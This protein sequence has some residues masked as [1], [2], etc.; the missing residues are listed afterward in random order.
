MTRFEAPVTSYS[1]A[2]WTACSKSCGLGVFCLL[3]VVCCLLFAV[4]CSLLVV[5]CSLFVVFFGC[6]QS[7]WLWWL[8]I[9]VCGFL[10]HWL[11]G[12]LDYLG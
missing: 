1:L 6:R 8:L 3:F 5:A 4:S 12:L 2:R 7:L 10:F 9:V 11:I